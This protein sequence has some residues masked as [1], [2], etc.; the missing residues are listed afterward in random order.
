VLD[1]V[2]TGVVVVGV[3]L[4]VV[5]AGF[6]DV[7]IV[8]LVDTVDEVVVDEVVVDEVAVDEVVVDE[9][10]VDEVVGVGTPSALRYQFTSGSC[11]HSPIVTPLNPVFTISSS[12]YPVKL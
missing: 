3:E 2:G 1:G 6:V 5:V 12:M 8:E 11:I 10:V 9:V 4:V 7:V